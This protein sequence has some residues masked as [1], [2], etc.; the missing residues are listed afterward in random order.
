MKTP[1]NFLEEYRKTLFHGEWPT[2]PEM[3]NITLQRFP[4]KKG[5]TQFEP[6]PFSLTYREIG[7]QVSRVKSHILGLGIKKGEKVALTG[8]NSVEW[9]VA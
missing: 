2:I 8:K 4:D 9:A 6:E 5:F 1:W 3:F 7:Q